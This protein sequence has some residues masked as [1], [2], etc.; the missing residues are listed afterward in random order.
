MST[1]TLRQLGR[2]VAKLLELPASELAQYKNNFAYIQSF[3]VSQ[4]DI[5]QALEK[6]TGTTEK[7]W[8]ITKVPVDEAIAHGREEIAKGNFMGMAD[9]MV[10]MSF[11]PGMGGFYEEKSSNRVLGLAEESLDEVITEFVKQEG[12]LS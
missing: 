6:A 3:N 11:K 8:Q 2:G 10:G 7:D 4:K 9:V 5:L 1:S 12:R